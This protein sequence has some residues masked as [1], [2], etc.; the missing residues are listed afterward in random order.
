MRHESVPSC[1]ICANPGT[2]EHESVI[3]AT[4]AVAG[5]W[6]TRKCADA[7][8]QARWLD[9]RPIVA[10]IGQAYVGYH[11]HAEG[12][13]LRTNPLKDRIWPNPWTAAERK[14]RS[15]ARIPEHLRTTPGRALEIGCGN[16]VNLAYLAAQGW[17]IA[18]QE[19]DPVAAEVASARLGIAI[20]TAPI[21]DTSWAD[22][23]FDL[24][25][26]NHVL[27]HLHDAAALLRKT[28][29]LLRPGGS[30]VHF[31][32]NAASIS[33]RLLGARWRG[34]EAPRHIVILTPRSG[35][36]LLS[37][38]G[39]DN[40]SST[41]FSGGAGGIA[42]D[43]LGLTASANAGRGRQMLAPLVTVV[44]EAIDVIAGLLRPESRWEVQFTGQAPRRPAPDHEAVL[45]PT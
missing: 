44:F 33:H 3:D 23:S 21:E 1:P 22:E 6:T 19:I 18:G 36:R 13:L 17:E 40:V 4:G 37:E 8:C 14:R 32:P 29:S 25:I 12:P 10:D 15:L 20:E 45:S 27:E 39:F 35:L 2:V 28:R 31:T 43:S 30:T 11:T 16:G 9:D 7:R 26:T 5:R 34:L 41:T 24:V 38:A 42:A